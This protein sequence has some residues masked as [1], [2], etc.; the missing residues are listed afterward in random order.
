MFL[1]ISIT[2]RTFLIKEAKD[3]SSNGSNL[4]NI[5]LTEEVEDFTPKIQAY[6]ASYPWRRQKIFPEWTQAHQSRSPMGKQKIL[7]QSIPSKEV[8]DSSLVSPIHRKIP[9]EEAEDSSSK[10]FMNHEG[11][12]RFFPSGSHI[13]TTPQGVSHLQAS[14]KR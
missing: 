9:S 1:N 13:Y 5:I 14:C 10:S 8:E 2:S 4:S 12:K 7:P 6:Q 3:F 11:I